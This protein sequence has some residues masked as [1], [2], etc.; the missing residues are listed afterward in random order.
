MSRY[1]PDIHHRRSVRLPGYDYAEEG[2]YFVTICTQGH[3]CVFGRV[4]KDKMLL[5]TAGAMVEKWWHELLNK[6]PFLRTD[7]HVVM[8]NHFHGIIHVGAALCCRPGVEKDRDGSGRPRRVAPTLGK[9]VGWFKTMTTNQY[10][11]GVKKEDWPSFPGRLW[12]RNYYEHLI[13]DEYEL[14]YYRTY[15]ANNPANWRADKENPN[16]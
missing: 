9:I 8:P 15:I 5:N 6:F 2:W 3:L 13:R 4:T 16:S 7:V 14:D 12:Q 11:R 1:D 10:I